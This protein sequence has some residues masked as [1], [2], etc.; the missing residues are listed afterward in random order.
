M[1]VFKFPLGI[2]AEDIVTGFKGRITG[3]VRYLTGCDQFSLTPRV[4]ED[5]PGKLGGSCWFDETRIKPI[6]GEAL[7]LEKETITPR[8]NNGPGDPAPNY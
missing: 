5:D 1:K 3:Q 6:K 4:K 8:A 7:T 2:M